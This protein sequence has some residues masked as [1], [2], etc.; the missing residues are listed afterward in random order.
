MRAQSATPP[1]SVVATDLYPARDRSF[2][3]RSSLMSGVSILLLKHHV[4]PGAL[5][6]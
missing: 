4:H 6:S 3:T 2:E 1:V 5:D